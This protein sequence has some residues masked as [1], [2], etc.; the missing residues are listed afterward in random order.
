M[1][2]DYTLDRVLDKIKRIGIINLKVN[3]IMINTDGKF[4][5]DITFK[6]AVMLMARV[7]KYRGICL[8]STYMN[9]KTYA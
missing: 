9:I 5:D 7:I 2:D 3:K 6:N 1:V 8:S 4:S